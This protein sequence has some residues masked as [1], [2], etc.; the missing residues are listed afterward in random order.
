M[1][2]IDTNESNWPIKEEKNKVY[3]LKVKVSINIMVIYSYSSVTISQLNTQLIK[4]ERGRA[5]PR[6]G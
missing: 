1:H 4:L 2:T 6:Q 5:D 3:L